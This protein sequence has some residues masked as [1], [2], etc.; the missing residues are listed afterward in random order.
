M[1]VSNVASLTI[2]AP[3]RYPDIHVVINVIIST[4]QFGIIWV[5]MNYRQYISAFDKQIK[6]KVE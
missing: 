6:R 2:V 3:D 4:A 5:Y 1:V